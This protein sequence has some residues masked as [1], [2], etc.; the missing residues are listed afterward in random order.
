MLH[1]QEGKREWKGFREPLHTDS[2]EEKSFHFYLRFIN[3]MTTTN[4]TIPTA[5]IPA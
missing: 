1:L 3:T 4:T 2:V 5:A